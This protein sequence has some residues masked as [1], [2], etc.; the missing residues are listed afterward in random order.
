MRAC[1]RNSAVALIAVWAVATASAAGPSY[2][3]ITWMS[4]ANIYY[5]IG[6]LG[7]V[8]DG[9]ITRIPLSN[10]YGGGGGLQVDAQGLQAGRRGGHAR[11][12]R[13]RRA[14]EGQPA[15]HRPQPLRPLLRHRHL[16]EP[17]R[18]ADH[19]LADHVL[20]GDGAE[21]C[22]PAAARRSTAARRSRCPTA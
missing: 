18:R 16:V 17:D 5:E 20:P 15:A 12:R 14:V 21:H 10:F 3:D 2:V 22:R 11:A 13:A 9:Y 8:T 7:V 4:I 19:R 6:S 1:V